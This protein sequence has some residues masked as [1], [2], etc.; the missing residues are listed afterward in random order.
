MSFVSQALLFLIGALIGH[1]LPRF[2][3]LLMSRGRG[4]NMHFPPHP[5]PMPL[6]PHLNQRI[7]HL[8]TF[9][10]LGLIVV[11]VP[12]GVGLASVRWGNPA[13]GFG[14]W[15]SAGW[16][17]INRLQSIISGQAPWTRGIAEKLQGVVN[18]STSENKCCGWATPVWGVTRIYCSNCD[19]KLLAMARPDLGRKRS[20]GRIIGTLRLL[21]SD[22]YPMV[23]MLDGD[24]LE[25]E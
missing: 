11:V 10:W 6:G 13:F 1:V 2:P 23:A 14:L 8:S 12:M 19:T 17:F 7:L 24:L 4:F 21:I 15:L 20:D 9:Y 25:E 18:R 5:E 16:F 3:V 22:G